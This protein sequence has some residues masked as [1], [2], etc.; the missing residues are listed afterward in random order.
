MGLV[1][2]SQTAIIGVIAYSGSSS[3]SLSSESLYLCSSQINIDVASWKGYRGGLGD[4]ALETTSDFVV[5][6]VAPFVFVHGP[7][8]PDIA[9]DASLSILE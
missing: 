4:D 1:S 6:Y 3:D 5:G 9:D 2:D 8:G 7:D